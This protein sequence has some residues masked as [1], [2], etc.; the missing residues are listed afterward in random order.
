MTATAAELAALRTVAVRLGRLREEVAFVGGMIR[1]LLITDPGAP[2]A[3]PTDDVDIVAAISSRTEY[4]ALAGRLR[5]LG[6]QEDHRDEAPLCRWT[7]D[8]LTVDIMPDHENVLGFSNRW[9][10]SARKTATWCASGRSGSVHRS[11]SHH[12]VVT[13]PGAAACRRASGG[14]C[15]RGTRSSPPAPNPRSWR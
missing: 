7:V 9:Y 14:T 5:T 13:G 8:G 11:A 4:Y 6:F 2:P 15:R 12:A 1:S 10:P 3:R